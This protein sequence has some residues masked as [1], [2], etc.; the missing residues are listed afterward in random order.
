MANNELQLNAAE[1]QEMLRRFPRASFWLRM[2]DRHPD[3]HP[4]LEQMAQ[5]NRN[6]NGN[7]YAGLL[8]APVQP[9]APPGLPAAPPAVPGFAPQAMYPP[10]FPVFPG[11]YPNHGYYPPAQFQPRAHPPYYH[12]RPEN[13]PAPATPRP[14]TAR[15]QVATTHVDI[16]V[17][18]NTE[19]ENGVV[20]RL[21]VR[22]P[23]DLPWND[24][25][26]RICANMDL[27]PA[28][29]VL[30]YKFSGDRISDPPNRLAN[31]EDHVQA[32]ARA[33]EK[34]KRARTREVVLEIHNLRAGA[35]KSKKESTATKG[36]KRPLADGNEDE[37]DT[38]V[39][40]ASQLRHCNNG[41]PAREGVHVIEE[42]VNELIKKISCVGPIL[43]V[44]VEEAKWSIWSK[45]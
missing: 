4:V 26:D 10:G 17:P 42:A 43:D 38:S 7:L 18:R 44:K 29:A 30:G 15:P 6:L 33:T 12:D 34:I 14:A 25:F 31:A 1:R 5:H 3:I 32:M 19:V 22:L 41:V 23:T 9:A 39:S 21:I 16:S 8:A 35:G 27:I 45:D 20:T 11:L 13:L 36:K 2:H 24:F 28:N 40:Y 37:L